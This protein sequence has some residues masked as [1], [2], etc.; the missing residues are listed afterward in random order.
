[1]R[2]IKTEIVVERMVVD[3]QGENSS[4]QSYLVRTQV[5][6]EA[7]FPKSGQDSLSSV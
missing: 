5:M 1:M 3:P 4:D 7:S 6:H 2:K